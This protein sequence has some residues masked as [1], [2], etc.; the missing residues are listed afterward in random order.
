MR[1]QRSLI[2]HSTGSLFDPLFSHCLRDTVITIALTCK[3]LGYKY[4]LGRVQGLFSQ[5]LQISFHLQ[6]K[7]KQPTRKIKKL[8]D[9]YYLE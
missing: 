3:S 1:F 4:I 5:T 2:K 6:T 7:E 8:K 9:M